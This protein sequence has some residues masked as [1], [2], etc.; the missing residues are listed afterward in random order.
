MSIDSFYRKFK[1]SELNLLLMDQLVKPPTFL[2]FS[3][4]QC[5]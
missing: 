2:E 5:L 4:A 1:A 3:G